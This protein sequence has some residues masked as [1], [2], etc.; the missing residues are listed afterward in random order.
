MNHT[1]VKN[2]TAFRMGIANV[3]DLQ[4]WVLE[5]KHIPGLVF[6]GRSNVGKSTLLNSMFG[7][8]ARTSKTPGR[9]QQV[10]IFECFLMLEDETTYP[11]YLFDIPGYGH[12]KVSKEMQQ[13]WEKLLFTLF[14]ELDDRHLII[15]L[16]DARHPAQKVDFFFYDFLKQFSLTS[17]LVLNKFDK[18]KNQKERNALKN[19]MPQIYKDF[20]NAQQIYTVSAEKLVG[21]PELEQGLVN[22]IL[23]NYEISN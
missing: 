23:K 14:R 17:F 20:K 12:A 9:T 21:I 6:A 13:N 16:Q 22:F 7:K 2:K 19:T 1:I 5:H 11:F 10:N 18:L 15:N 3:S 4:K 8:V